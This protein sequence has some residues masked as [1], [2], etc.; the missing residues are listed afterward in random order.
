MFITGLRCKMYFYY[1]SQSKRV[2]VTAMV[3]ANASSSGASLTHWMLLPILSLHDDPLGQRLPGIPHQSSEQAFQ[4]GHPGV[5][6]KR[7]HYIFLSN[8][9]YWPYHSWSFV[10]RPRTFYPVY[11]LEFCK[12]LPQQGKFLS[13][14]SEVFLEST[15]ALFQ[16]FF[17]TRL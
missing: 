15:E 11:D 12:L 3:C 1:G 10:R 16:P 14:K 8:T 7:A 2:K 17:S 13:S 9:N 4:Q 6:L 5:K